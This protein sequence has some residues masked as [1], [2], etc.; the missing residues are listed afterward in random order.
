MHLAAVNSTYIITNTYFINT[1]SIK[2]AVFTEYILSV[3][4]KNTFFDY[5]AQALAWDR[6]HCCRDGGAD[7]V[8]QTRVQ[9]FGPILK[10]D[11]K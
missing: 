5:L 8:W 10:C 2:F 9:T 11:A 7:G 1:V 3:N 6:S 4:L